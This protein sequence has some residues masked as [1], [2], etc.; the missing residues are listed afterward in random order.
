M[1]LHGLAT[2]TKDYIFTMSRVSKTNPIPLDPAATLVSTKPFNSCSRFKQ[3]FVQFVKLP[4]FFAISYL[5]LKA[6]TPF[7]AHTPED[8][9]HKPI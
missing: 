6:R 3:R 1:L 5:E 7:G 2:I 9:L 8:D 4:V